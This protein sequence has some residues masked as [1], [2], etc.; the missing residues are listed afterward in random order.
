MAC[1]SLMQ[2]KVWRR[3][4]ALNALPVMKNNCPVLFDNTSGRT[5]VAAITNKTEKEVHLMWHF[6]P[7]FPF[8]DESQAPRVSVSFLS[9]F[10]WR[11]RSWANVNHASHMAHIRSPTIISCELH[12]REAGE[13]EIAKIQVCMRFVKCNEMSHTEAFAFLYNFILSRIHQNYSKFISGTQSVSLV[14]NL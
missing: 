13:T 12:N 8:V 11:E 3:R 2:V 6:L 1:G 10:D 14:Q 4:I 9:W 5:K 7:S